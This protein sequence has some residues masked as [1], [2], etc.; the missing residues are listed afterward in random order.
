[1]PTD[2][3]WPGRTLAPATFL[4]LAILGPWVAGPSAT[5]QEPSRDDILR[6]ALRPERTCFDVI[7]Y[8]LDVRIDPEA[9]SVGGSNT[10]VFDARQD[11]RVLQIDLFSNMEVLG[12]T[13][14][15]DAG[16]LDFRREENSIF[17]TLPEVLEPGSRHRLLVEYA[18]TPIVAERPPWIGGFT[19]AEDARG[20][21]WVAVTSQGTGASLWWPHKD[22]PADEPERVSLS[23]TVPP[24]LE[25]VSNGRLVERTPLEDG[26]T[27][28][29]WEVSYPINNYCVTINIA[30][31]AYFRDEYRRE[32]GSVLS[33]D[34]YVL[35]ENLE[36]AKA[37]FEQ[38]KSM[39]EAFEHH[40]GRYPFERDGFKLVESPHLG[41]EHQSAIAYGNGYQG[42]YLGRSPSEVGLKFDFIIIHEAA[43]EWWGNSVTMSDE[44]DLWIHE[45][46]GAYAESLFVEHVF[47]REAALDYINAKKPN[48][49]NAA[50]IIG[51]YGQNRSGDPDMYDK[52]QLVLNTLR[53]VLD[54][55]E[56]WFATLREIQE[57]FRYRNIS[58]DMLFGFINARTG[59]DLTAFFDQ[60]LRHPGLPVLQL[61]FDPDGDD[62]VVRYRWE[63]DVETFAMPIRVTVA[64]DRF[65]EILPTG[66]WQELRLQ[67]ITPDAFEVAEDLYY[68]AV[69][70][71]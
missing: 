51:P 45:S 30:D 54:D 22:H 53:S 4:L 6:G 33:L 32:D 44:A 63:A 64:P 18:G 26:W 16:R 39:L 59:R 17:V 60:Y 50:P 49:R 35:P 9:K 57:T 7:E 3:R 55:D 36:K 19:W 37:H 52:G 14:D 13:L 11:C 28:F 47:G 67:G 65:E 43:H 10:I 15:D 21:P 34:Y 56:L 8:H 25:D 23:V 38:T 20:K 46:F 24:G 27:R 58:A 71:V 68:V 40:F 41:M 42:G 5:A 12:I 48:V 69:D 70:R 62:L 1:M 29:V 61:R 2:N 66:D 31:Y